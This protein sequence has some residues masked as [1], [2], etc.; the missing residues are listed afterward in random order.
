MLG[1]IQGQFGLI[2]PCSYILYMKR[3]WPF[4]RLFKNQPIQLLWRTIQT[5]NLKTV[6][7]FEVN[8]TFRFRLVLLSQGNHEKKPY[9]IPAQVL[10]RHQKQLFYSLLSIRPKYY[11]SSNSE[12]SDS[13]SFINRLTPLIFFQGFEIFSRG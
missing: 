9:E 6:D 1:A 5:S 13:T 8:Q 4:Q 2:W 3:F 12:Y 10:N 11:E 7:W